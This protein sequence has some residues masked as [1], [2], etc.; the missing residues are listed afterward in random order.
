MFKADWG[1]NGMP[2]H[3]R[4]SV[5]QTAPR[6]Q[7]EVQPGNVL[8]DGNR[9][10]RYQ[11]RPFRALP[12]SAACRNQSIAQRFSLLCLAAN[13]CIARAAF[14]GSPLS[15]RSLPMSSL[16]FLSPSVASLLSTV[17]AIL[18]LIASVSSAAA[19]TPAEMSQ[20]ESNFKEASANG[21]NLTSAEFKAFIDLN[22][23]DNLGRAVKIQA[24]GAYNKAFSKV[25]AN[26]DGA[27]TWDEFV[28]AQ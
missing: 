16:E 26:Q 7:P 25:D 19:L 28:A 2:I 20:A 9:S 21:S 1:S 12:C 5:P 14:A 4:G 13:V 17:G 8:D 27:V 11:L 15:N 6:R 18:C 10:G 24:N 23:A 22:A 3:K